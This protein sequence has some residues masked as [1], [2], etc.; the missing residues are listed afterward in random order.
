MN[1]IKLKP[2][3]TE[4]IWGGNNLKLKYGK[5]SDFSV[6]ESWELSGYPGK[7]SV[8]VGGKYD[9]KTITEII[10]AEGKTVLGSKAECYDK[11]P[12]LI[13]LI[14]AA[15]PLSIQVHP[16]DENANVLGAFGGKTEMWIICESEPDAF[17]YFGVKEKLSGEQ[18]KNAILDGTI[19]DY[20]N[21]VSV[22]KGDTFFI[23]AGT[24]HAI[25]AG[26]TICEIQQTS[27]TTYR[28]FDYKRKDK[29]GNERELHIEKGMIASNLEPIDKFYEE[30]KLEGNE[31]KLV[32]CPFFNVSRIEVNGSSDAMVENDSFAAFTVTDGVGEISCDGEAI[33]VSKGDT[34]FA[35]A[36]CG[37]VLF[38]G[39]MT[40][41]KST[42]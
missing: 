31:L 33:C 9:G 8:A 21:K 16:S 38:D 29:N 30:G 13:K 4:A 20:L 23:E 41:I 7:E 34:V 17:L 18:F 12:L 19:T 3:L 27:D 1:I 5:E 6:A 36:G 39:V 28:L 14:D 25:G 32:S 40:V 10:E 2:Y 22:K 26:I 15:Q 35:P 11:F 42:M 37:I 24:I